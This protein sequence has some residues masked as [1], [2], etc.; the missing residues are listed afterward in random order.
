[1]TRR[2]LRAAAAI[3][4]GLL[5]G[6][7]A[8]PVER[9]QPPRPALA[10]LT[11]ERIALDPG[12]P[13]R[14]RL[15]GLVLLDIWEVSSR[16]VRFGGVSAM[17]VE[18]G[19]VL[20]FSDS[21]SVFRF[22]APEREG[23]HQLRIE[24]LGRGPGDGRSKGDRDIESLVA[25]GGA[26]WLAFEGRNAVWRY[27]RPDLAF[28]AAA[29]PEAIRGLPYT[30]GPEA[31]ARLG[32]GRFLILSEG[33][34]AAD[35]TTPAFLFEGDPALTAT[36]VRALRYRP[37]ESFR[38][39]EAAALPDGRLLVLNRSFDIFRGWEA[40]LTV[41][42]PVRSGAVIEGRPLASFTGAVARDN[43][44]ALSVDRERGRTIVWIASDDNFMP[45][46]Q[47]TLLMKFALAE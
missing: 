33:P 20:A 9:E 42:D 15:G 45:L 24:R 29:A 19:E 2:R 7:F 4:A 23:R 11:A 6:T 41:V 39:T 22:P 36:R 40:V 32:D 10:E 17:H 28:D 5:V 1:M 37:P 46:V 27:R 35:G 34:A 38:A 25:A 31:M 3:G 14:R 43:M 47:R 18:G 30:R 44:E 8:W 13:R 26:L 12:D 16:D 21:G